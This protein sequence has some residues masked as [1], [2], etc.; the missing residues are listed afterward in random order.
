[1]HTNA[2]IVLNRGAKYERDHKLYDSMLL[3][4]FPKYFKLLERNES[5]VLIWRSSQMAHADCEAH[6][7]P[8]SD[9]QW[10]DDMQS[11]VRG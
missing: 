1:M 11:E 2:V 3:D 6:A 10:K 9:K 8:L 4:I 7:R 5:S